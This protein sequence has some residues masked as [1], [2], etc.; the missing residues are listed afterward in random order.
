MFPDSKRLPSEIK[1]I[2]FGL[3]TAYLSDEYKNMRA[4]VGTVYTMAPQGKFNER[5]LYVHAG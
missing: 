4:K 1:L 2:D 3:A 5:V